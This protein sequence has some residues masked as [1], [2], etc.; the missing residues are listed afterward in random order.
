M[1]FAFYSKLNDNRFI[2]DK[3]RTIFDYRPFQSFCSTRLYD[4]V[5]PIN[6]VY[7]DYDQKKPIEYLS[8]WIVSTISH[9]GLRCQPYWCISLFVKLHFSSWHSSF[10]H[11]YFLHLLTAHGLTYVQ[12]LT[13]YWNNHTE[14]KFLRDGLFIYKTISCLM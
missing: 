1:T 8:I 14:K 13:K 5:R 7:I 2:D 3:Y 10:H 9:R 4:L 6:G 12:F 11:T